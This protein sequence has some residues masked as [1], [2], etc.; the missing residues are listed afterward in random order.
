MAGA[1]QGQDRV[2]TKQNLIHLSLA[3]D[4]VAPPPWDPSHDQGAGVHAPF[5]NVT[6][7]CIF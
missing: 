2:S 7:Q 6:P 4:V 3:I 1:L 5:L